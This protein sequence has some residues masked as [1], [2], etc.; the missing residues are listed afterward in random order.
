MINRV[1]VCVCLC[2]C[3]SMIK[4][5]VCVS[6]LLQNDKNR[7]Y[8]CVC[9]FVF[10]CFSMI[11]FLWSPTGIA[12]RVME[13]STFY[14]IRLQ[15]FRN[16]FGSFEM[17]VFAGLIGSYAG[18]KGWKQGL[19]AGKGAIGEF[20]RGMMALPKSLVPKNVWGTLYMGLIIAKITFIAKLTYPLSMSVFWSPNGKLLSLASHL[21]I[22]LVYLGSY[23]VLLDSA[24]R[25]RL[26]ATT[27]KH[28]NL[29]LSLSSALTAFRLFPS[30][31]DRAVLPFVSGLVSLSS[32]TIAKL[33]EG[34]K[35]A[36]D[37]NIWI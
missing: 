30:G 6:V 28:L 21:A 1:C 13:G 12:G 31:T 29:G 32:Y 17:A 19:D 35:E 4:V 16:I 3:L 18:F 20:F 15:G 7:V 24:N 26:K 14:S 2:V 22:E 5:C 11:S 9:V 8:A 37:Q 23:L 10:C 34:R 36:S 25:N 33:D 27:F